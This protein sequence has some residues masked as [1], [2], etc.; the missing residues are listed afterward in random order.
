MV[1][2]VDLITRLRL[3]LVEVKQRAKARTRAGGRG[4]VMRELEVRRL[5]MTCSGQTQTTSDR[6]KQ[7]NSHSSPVTLKGTTD[8]LC[9]A[10]Y[11]TKSY[12][13]HAAVREF[14]APPLY[15]SKLR[16]LRRGVNGKLKIKRI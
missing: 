15:W 8:V 4:E 5:R 11:V 13:G 12:V 16:L 9:Q 14:L 7:E 2:I 10:W 3:P 6:W 1:T